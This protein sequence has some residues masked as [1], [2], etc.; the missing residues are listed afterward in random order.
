MEEKVSVGIKEKHDL[1]NKWKFTYKPNVT[2]KKKKQSEKDWLS[3]YKMI[4]P[5][6]AS[7]E[8]FWCVKNNI[9]PWS[10]LHYGS[11]YAFF[12]NE[13]NPSWEDDKNKEGCSY[14]FYF[15]KN[16]TNEK[17]LD[18]V[19]ESSLVFLIGETSMFSDCVNG[20][21]FERKQRGDKMIVWCNAHSPEMLENV[22]TGILPKQ[23]ESE[24]NFE[25]GDLTDSRY[26]VSVKVV[27]HQS[28]LQRINSH[29]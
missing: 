2:H 24:T 15:N 12:K 27:D 22:T 23:F 9:K 13:I 18:D 16:K 6:I 21:T 19:F 17:D 1:E 5:K 11:I 10:E 29:K 4:H 7:V 25:T 26:K 14:M 8:M 20:I 3:T 28:E